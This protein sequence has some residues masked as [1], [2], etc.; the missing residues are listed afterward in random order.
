MR[1]L[2]PGQESIA[3]RIH[4]V[5]GGR[6]FTPNN[7]MTIEEW[8]EI[9]RHFGSEETVRDDS[10]FAE[11]MTADEMQL[12]RWNEKMRRNGH[13]E[14]SLEEWPDIRSCLPRRP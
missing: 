4:G 2:C 10:L 13:R 1:R 3:H 6:A 14:A 8:R 11:P 5:Q 12:E 9:L 7:D